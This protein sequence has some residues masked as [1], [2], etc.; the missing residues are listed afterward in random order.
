MA[1]INLP[2]SPDAVKKENDNFEAYW[3]A[4]IAPI[5]G[6]LTMKLENVDIIKEVIFISKI[7]NRH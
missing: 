6:S 2:T 3:R 1:Q 5:L 7:C 4:K